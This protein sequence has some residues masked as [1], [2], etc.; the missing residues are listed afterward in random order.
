MPQVISLSLALHPPSFLLPPTL[1]RTFYLPAPFSFHLLS[2]RFHLA[3]FLFNYSGHY[4]VNILLKLCQGGV[5]NLSKTISPKN[6]AWRHYELSPHY[7]VKAI[8]AIMN[9][10]YFGWAPHLTLN[11]SLTC[12]LIKPWGHSPCNTLATSSQGHIN[13]SSRDSS[14]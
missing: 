5:R 10:V 4:N 3:K 13:N 1:R 6:V 9:S 11:F 7:L 14:E 12:G 2:G 8:S